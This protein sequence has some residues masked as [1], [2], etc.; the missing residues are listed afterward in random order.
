MAVTLAVIGSPAS[1]AQPP[2]APTLPI[3]QKYFAPGP[4]RVSAVQGF[5]CC[6]SSGARFDVWYPTDLGAGGFRHPVITWGNG[7]NARPGQYAYLLSHLATW[8]FVVVASENVNTGTGQEILDAG[9]WMTTQND[10]ASSIFSHVLAP[11]SVGAIGHSQGAAGVLN[12]MM[13]SGGLITTAIPIELAAQ[14]FCTSSASCADTRN[15]SGGSIFLINGSADAMISPSTQL[16][17]W[18]LA[19]LQSDSAYY[20][21]A[22]ASVPKAWGTLI[23]P[24]HNDVQGQ[25]GC[26]QA[27]VPCVNG[28]Y[29][30]LGY[31]TA[32][33]MDR[34][35]GDSYAHQ[36]F[37]NGSGEFF[38]ETTNWSNQASTV[39]R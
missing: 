1:A 3:E 37:V 34:L 25:P 16:L 21:A 13:K 29:G 4:W 27:S 20:Q 9:R 17:P 26:A 10:Q 15:L 22:P 35:Q 5:G 39:A 31:L 11:A 38:H 33:M 23:G 8:G 36:A 19:G 6:D 30:Y 14:T 28:V 7:T 2:N 12:A 32:W 24:D 18:Q